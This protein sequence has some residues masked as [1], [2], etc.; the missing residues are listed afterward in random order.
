MS[1]NPKGIMLEW[2]LIS[3]TT[4]KKR[5]IP[6]KC[7]T[8]IQKVKIYLMFGEYCSSKEDSKFGEINTAC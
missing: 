6:M 3:I 8:E 1:L 2:H 7:R 5:M 4:S